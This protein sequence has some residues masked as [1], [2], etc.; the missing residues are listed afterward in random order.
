MQRAEAWR[1]HA[2]KSRRWELLPKGRTELAKQLKRQE[3]HANLV[4]PRCH[5]TR[6]DCM[7]EFKQSESSHLVRELYTLNHERD[8]GAN[9]NGN[10]CDWIPALCGFPRLT[11]TIPFGPG[12]SSDLTREFSVS[13]SLRRPR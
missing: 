13:E 6:I 10:R 2:Q 11:S 3:F 1:L 4:L 8:T 7:V 9:R 5:L 12:S